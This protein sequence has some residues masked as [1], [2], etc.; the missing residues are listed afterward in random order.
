M[1]DLGGNERKVKNHSLRRYI[2]SAK[3]RFKARTAALSFCPSGRDLSWKSRYRTSDGVFGRMGDRSRAP[4]LAS[5][6]M[7]LNRS[8]STLSAAESL[9]S[10]CGSERNPPECKRQRFPAGTPHAGQGTENNCLGVRSLILMDKGCDETCEK[11]IPFGTLLGKVETPGSH[12]L[13]SE[14]VVAF[15]EIGI[16]GNFTSL[17]DAFTKQVDYF[18]WFVTRSRRWLAPSIVGRSHPS[19]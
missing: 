12:R 2:R 3:T 19:R 14:W 11:A 18:E 1:R 15:P 7:R 16:R 17:V 8:T 4:R 5:A 10:T 9:R 13:P 6:W